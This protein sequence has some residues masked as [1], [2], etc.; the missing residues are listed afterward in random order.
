MGLNNS[1]LQGQFRFEDPD[2]E[3]V[4]RAVWERL[5]QDRYSD[6]LNKIRIKAMK[7]FGAEYVEELRDHPVD[8][9]RVPIWNRFVDYWQSPEFLRRSEA[10]KK[11]RS[12]CPEASVHVGGSQTFGD[13]KRAM[14]LVFFF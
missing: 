8:G 2:D 6:D 3:E 13:T 5:I 9:I 11:N 4:A 14:V 12:V 7:H 1:I 10:A